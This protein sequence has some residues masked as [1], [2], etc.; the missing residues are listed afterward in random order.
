MDTPGR[1]LRV[2]RA[3]PG[4]V[5][6]SWPVV[7]WALVARGMEV[8]SSRHCAWVWRAG[9][10]ERRMPGAGLCLAPKRLFVH[11]PRVRH[12]CNSAFA[13]AHTCAF[14]TGVG[15]KCWGK[16]DY[17]QLGYNDVY[18]KKA[19]NM[20]LAPPEAGLLRRLAWHKHTCDETL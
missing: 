7:E 9:R 14:A 11:A 13:G 6:N 20:R 1:G 8:W 16:N 17:G 5:T 2:A 10:R 3:S 15:L 18:E 4:F 12:G 19:Q